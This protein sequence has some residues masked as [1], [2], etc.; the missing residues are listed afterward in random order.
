MNNLPIGIFDSGIG[1]LTVASA[2]VKVLPHEQLIYFGDTAHLPYGDKSPEAIKYY[3]LRIAKFLADKKCKAIV[4]A[5]NTASSLA[6][7]DLV[8]FMGHELPIFNVIDPVVDAVVE[9]HSYTRVGVIA[10]K[11]TIK[12][13]VFKHKIQARNAL[14]QVQS[15]A[16]P[17]L[18]PMIEEGFFNNKISR[19]IID[20]YLSSSKLK[21]IE[22]LIL[23]CTHYPLIQKEIEA[24][25]KYQVNIINTADI[26]ASYIKNQLISMDLVNR[27]EEMG[28][29]NQHEFYVSDY[30]N[31]FEQ[32]ATMFFKEKIHLKHQAIWD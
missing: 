26:V 2:I 32:S 23:A 17:L 15:L 5:C 31:S 3:S 1:G 20:S 4:I 22:C 7:S 29:K 9:Q 10:T 8:N 16:T 27:S 6:Y 19:T 13:G 30:T 28:K 11:A 14:I 24:Y 25:Y 12:S 18:A 21:N